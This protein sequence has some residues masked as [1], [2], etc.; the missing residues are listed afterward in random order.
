MQKKLK[1]A[2]SWWKYFQSQRESEYIPKTI[3]LKYSIMTRHRYKSVEKQRDEISDDT[4][5]I[6]KFSIS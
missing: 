1:I 2:G 6:V 3:F 5:M 4:I